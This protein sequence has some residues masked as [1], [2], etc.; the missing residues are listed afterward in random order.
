MLHTAGWLEGGLVM[1]Y[2]KFI[3]DCDQAS[4]ISILLGGIDMSENAQAMGAFKEVGPG[5]HFLG[6]EHTLSNFETAFYRSTVADNNSYEQWSNEGS[7]DTAQRANVI[8]KKMLK[9]YQP[10]FFEPAIDE[11]LRTFMA[12]Q[13][14]SFADRDY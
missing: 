4:M 13:K 9:D 7:L 1:G 8:W 2:E 5:K 14:A 11:S 3:M 6:S 12:Q 10:P